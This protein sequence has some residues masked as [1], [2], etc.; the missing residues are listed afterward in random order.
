MNARLRTRPFR[1]AVRT[2]S[3]LLFSLPFV[4]CG[5]RNPSDGQTKTQAAGKG[6]PLF[7]RSPMDPSVTSP[8]PAKDSMGMDYLPVY[9]NEA[10]GANGASR[11]ANPV[12]GFATVKESAGG[13]RLAGIQTAPVVRES[14]AR[15]TRTVG[16]VTPDERRIRQVRTKVSGWVEKLYVNYTG[17]QVRTGQ[18]VLAIYSP[19]LLASEEEYLRARAAAERF[20]ASSIPEVRRGGEDLVASARRRLEL[21]DV[22]QSFLSTLERTGKAQRTVTLVAPASGF[23]TTK[24]VL[25][26]MEVQPGSE[27]FTLTDLSHVWVEADFYENEAR[28]LAVGQRAE[29]RL[30]YEPGHAMSAEVTFISPVLNPETRT[31]KVRLELANPGGHLKPGMFVDVTSELSSTVGVTIPE[32]AVID[33]GLRQVVFVEREPGTFEPREVEVGIRGDGRVAIVSGLR[34]GEK[35]AT[36]ANFLLDAESKLRA[37]LAAAQPPTPPT[38]PAPPR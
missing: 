19:E 26:G 29:V 13:I 14:L 34:E 20:A 3:F 9:A 22:P 1:L 6:A 12:P 27:L 7:Y 24:T 15:T 35:V 21:F 2:L 23:V 8:T 36:R 18:P 10:S 5:S 11:E 28:L 33:S 38:P 4:G 30:P 25:E 37:A 17:Q 31:L 32:D 16:S